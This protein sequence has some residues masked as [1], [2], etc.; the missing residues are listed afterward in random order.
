MVQATYWRK[1]KPNGKIDSSLT[2]PASSS[3]PA[4]TGRACS[5]GD[6]KPI[7][8]EQTAV[9]VLVQIFKNI[10]NHL[11]DTTVGMCGQVIFDGLHG[12]SR[13]QLVRE[14]ELARGDAAEGNALK[15]V[16]IGQLH[17][18]TI[19]GGQL[20]LLKRCRNTIGDNGADRVDDVFA[21]QVVGFRDFGSPRGFQMSLL[22][23]QS[24][25]FLAQLHARRRMDG[26]VDAPVQRMETTQHLRIGGVHD[27]I[28]AE[29]GDVALPQQQLFS[30]RDVPWRVSTCTAI[31]FRIVSSL[32]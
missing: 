26:V 1:S 30:C 24:V 14:A 2:S 25:A 23:H 18:G 11:F 3:R 29:T 12:N 19:A 21:R 17:N 10:E 20:L 6:E 8:L 32:S 5:R 22:L 9:N 16:F 15:A 27:G 7:L 28:Y 4:S 13:G 31:I